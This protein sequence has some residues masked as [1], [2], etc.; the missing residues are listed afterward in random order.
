MIPAISKKWN[1]E[2]KSK[3]L[4]SDLARH[5]H[6]V[7]MLKYALRTSIWYKFNH[8][9]TETHDP[10]WT[11]YGKYYVSGHCTPEFRQVHQ[12]HWKAQRKGVWDILIKLRSGHC[13]SNGVYEYITYKI[14]LQCWTVLTQIVVPLSTSTIRKINVRYLVASIIKG[15]ARAD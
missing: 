3:F 4:C 13:N 11:I 10:T 5:L 9:Y 6:R 14:S 8:L 7:I 15:N 1:N 2:K 12:I